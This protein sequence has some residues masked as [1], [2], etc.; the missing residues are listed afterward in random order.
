M[1]VAHTIAECR[2]Q[3]ARLGR[4]AFVPTMGALH[5][6]HMSLVRI[7]REHAPHVVLSVFVN[8][9]QFGPS[10]D[11]TQYPRPIEQD[12]ALCQEA[13]VDMVFNPQPAEIYPAGAPEIAIDLPQ[14]TG[15]LEGRSRP[16]H[17]RGVC[18]V[19]AKLFNIVEPQVACFGRKDFQ[20]LAIIR[21]MAQAL[22]FPIEIIGCPIV[23]DPDGLAM[24]SRNRYLSPEERSRALSLNRALLA[25]K[26]EAAGVNQCNRLVTLVR[27]AI[28]DPGKL[29]HLPV[30][31]DY[32]AAVDAATLK[33]VELVSGPTAILVAVRIGATRL[34]DNVVVGI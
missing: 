2:A 16:T 15:T 12:L 30:S 19:V 3:R 34:I 11:F 8:P 22:D 17:F 1:T 33:P 31:I 18:Q 5:E 24:S 20:Q 7:A 27:N 13:G 14:L 23:R 9:T 25:A 6:G 4:V 10:E 26:A 21:A 32:V 29:G 28:L